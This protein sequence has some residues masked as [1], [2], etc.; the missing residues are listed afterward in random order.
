MKDTQGNVLYE[1]NY[2]YGASVKLPSFSAQNKTISYT[3]NALSSIS[4]INLIGESKV[5]N[6][7][8][9]S[10]HI[11]LSSC[12]SGTSELKKLEYNLTSDNKLSSSINERCRDAVMNWQYEYFVDS[13]GLAKASLNSGSGNAL[14]DGYCLE[15]L[16]SAS[17]ENGYKFTEPEKNNLS[18]L[19]LKLNFDDRLKASKMKDEIKKE[20]SQTKAKLKNK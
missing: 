9:Y 7:Y 11:S 4:E 1:A 5:V 20:I 15:D 19:S 17:G 6:I 14:L 2:A 3:Y 16:Y 18:M 8:E 10:Q 13:P 12:M